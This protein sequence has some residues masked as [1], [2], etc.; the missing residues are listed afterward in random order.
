MTKMVETSPL[1][2]VL[3]DLQ[4]LCFHVLSEHVLVVKGKCP[5]NCSGV[6]K[7]PAGYSNKYEDIFSGAVRRAKEGTGVVR[8]NQILHKGSQMIDQETATLTD[9]N[10]FLGDRLW[11]KIFIIP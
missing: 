7:L 1:F 3:C 2:E 5:C 4:S 11:V 10:I 8:E 6:W 9:M